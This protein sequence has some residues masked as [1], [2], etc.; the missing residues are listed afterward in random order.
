MDIFELEILTPNGVIFHDNVIEATFPGEEGEFGI[1]AHHST[2]TTL[3]QTGV[4]EV[5]K[6]DN[7]IEAVL[8]DWGV[9]QVDSDHVTVLAD[10]AVAI[11]GDTQSSI[12]KSI[13][14][15]K[16]LMHSVAPSASVIASV[17]AKLEN[18]ATQVL[19]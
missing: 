8:V 5:A 13:D 4:I 7:S 14:D 3:L 19:M 16:E 9:V 11:K 17:S 18:L 6:Q 1:L 2:V 12:A 15:A 10:G